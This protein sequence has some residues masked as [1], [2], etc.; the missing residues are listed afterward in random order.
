M[1]RAVH[2]KVLFSR[3]SLD[4]EEGGD[5]EC[6]EDS[7]FVLSGICWG[8]LL[9]VFARAQELCGGR[10]GHSGLPASVIVPMVSVDVQQR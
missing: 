4:Y 3:R 2:Q 7:P 8:V 6:S 10:G 5:S 9:F 1:V